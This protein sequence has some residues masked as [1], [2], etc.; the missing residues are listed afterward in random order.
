[1]PDSGR[2]DSLATMV[3]HWF[4]KLV[5]KIFQRLPRRV[6]YDRNTES[7]YLERFYLIKTPALEIVLHHLLRP[8]SDF[9]LHN[10]P[11][12]WALSLIVVGGYIEERLQEDMGTRVRAFHRGQ[13]N[14]I[15]SETFHRISSLL[16]EEVWTLFI[17]GR[18]NK[19]WRFLD[20]QTLDVAN[21][22]G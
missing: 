14:V 9:R 21:E 10:H 15:E 4:I 22:N 19:D 8:D 11:W 12:G 17:H 6:I 3:H 7:T 1:M 5:E 16:S 18:R 20:V 2:A 13:L